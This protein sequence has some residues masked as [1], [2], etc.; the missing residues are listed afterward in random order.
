M[1]RVVRFVCALALLFDMCRSEACYSFEGILRG[2]RHPVGIVPLSKQQL[3]VGEHRGVI[4]QVP[5][6][7][8]ENAHVFLNITSQVATS[9][10]PADERGLLSFVLDPDFAHEKSVYICGVSGH[11]SALKAVAEVVLL[12]VAQRNHRYNGGHLLFGPD[13]CLYVTTG[14]DASNGSHRFDLN[15]LLGKILRL[16]VRGH[17]LYA[18]PDDNPFVGFGPSVLPEVFA[19]GFQNPWR[20]TVYPSKSSNAELL[21]GDTGVEPHRPQEEVYL[22]KAGMRHGWPDTNNGVLKTGGGAPPVYRYSRAGGQAIVAGVVYG[23]R[24]LPALQG[25]FLYA[26]FVHGSLHAL[27]PVAD[28]NTWISEDLCLQT[29]NDQQSGPFHVLTI[30]TDADGEPLVLTTSDLSN[31]VPAGVVYRLK[32]GTCHNSHGAFRAMAFR[33]TIWMVALAYAAR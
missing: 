33:P 20:C 24:A 12:R 10:A 21:C 32:D 19:Y 14:D 2:L 17:Q 7:A 6:G 4:L 1:R 25:K 11:G 18:V 28:Q 15:S 9:N 5:L 16:D 29:C 23:G 27:R 8:P 31:D 3:L 26:D 13:R 22:V 30:A